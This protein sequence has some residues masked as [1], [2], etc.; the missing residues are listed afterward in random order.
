MDDIVTTY[1]D[2][3]L[4]LQQNWAEIPFGGAYPGPVLD[5]FAVVIRDAD[6]VKVRTPLRPDTNKWGVVMAFSTDL[7]D[8]IPAI[9]EKFADSTGNTVEYR[10]ASDGDMMTWRPITTAFAHDTAE[11]N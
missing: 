3:L 7:T 4:Y 2:A 1:E 9:I 5:H 8:Q 10:L 6:L 11:G